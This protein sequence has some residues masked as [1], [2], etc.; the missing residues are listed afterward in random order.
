[1][2]YATTPVRRMTR[3]FLFHLLVAVSAFVMIY[4][5]LWLA[6]SSLKPAGEIWTRVLS[7]VPNEPTFVN[8]VNG[9]QGF[10]GV[11]FGTFFRNSI[12]ISVMGTVFVI[13]SSTVIAYGFARIDFPGKNVWFSCMLA[14]L[15][16]PVQIKIIP[17]YVF[18]GYLGWINTFLPLVVPQLFGEAF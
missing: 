2:A 11:T 12:V 13:M 18:F 1:M 7:L 17:Q 14:T 8:Y 6:A 15:M 3:T 16:L 4:P 5:I 10:G 9:W